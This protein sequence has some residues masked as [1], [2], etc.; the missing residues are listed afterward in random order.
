MQ[1]TVAGV[2]SSENQ[3]KE[4]VSALRE[5]GFDRE[6]SIVARDNSRREGRGG[7]SELTNDSTAD[8]MMTGGIMGGI[9]GLALTAGVIAIPGIGP[10]LAAGP[11]A[12]TLGGVAAGGIAGGLIDYGI[13][14]E[15]SKHYEESVRQG[16]ILALVRCSREKAD[17]AQDIL[18]R[19]G[20]KDIEMH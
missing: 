5:K 18:R 11:L 9:A 12:A 7:D 10:L 19:H 8:G 6:I 20:A 3:A 1:Q 15:H 4:A 2:F 17:V 14:E 13:P 16:D